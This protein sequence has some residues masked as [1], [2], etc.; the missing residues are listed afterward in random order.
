[1]TV[2]PS[3]ST[4]T[5][6]CLAVLWENWQV[7]G[8]QLEGHGRPQRFVANPTAIHVRQALPWHVSSVFAASRRVSDDSKRWSYWRDTA[9]AAGLLTIGAVTKSRRVTASEQG[10]LVHHVSSELGF[11]SARG[12]IRLG[13]PRANQKPVI[14]VYDSR[15]R[16][17]AFVKVAWN[18]L[19]RRLLESEQAALES[20]SAVEM[21][22]VTIPSVLSHGALGDATWLATAPLTVK[23]VR[24]TAQQA[25]AAARQIETSSARWEGVTHSSPLVQRLRPESDGLAV[26]AVAFERMLERWGDHDMRTGASHG[27]FVPWNLLSGPASTAIWDW[28]RFSPSRPLGFDRVHYRVQVGLHRHHRPLSE[29]VASVGRE[30]DS[31]LPD[32]PRRLREPHFQWYLLEMLMRYESDAD[33]ESSRFLLKLVKELDEALIARRMVT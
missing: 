15:G 12:T 11:A 25:D 20:L 2:A 33:D 7:G 9:A 14:Q 1:M 24:P 30:L 32:L 19:T 26:G 31:I 5:Q 22:E 18:E 29:A 21:L 8:W 4:V 27:D 6:P 13:P 16:T 28:E 10:S 23:R 17:L 3:R